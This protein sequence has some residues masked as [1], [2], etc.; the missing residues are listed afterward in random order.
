VN[1][2]LFHLGILTKTDKESTLALS[3]IFGRQ[4][5][6]KPYLSQATLKLNAGNAIHLARFARFSHQES[7]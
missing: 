5:E 3:K 6:N 7:L 2:V 1:P 4:S